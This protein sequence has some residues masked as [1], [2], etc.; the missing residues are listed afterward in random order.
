MLGVRRAIHIL[1]A[2]TVFVAGHAAAQNVRVPT[3]YDARNQLIG[4][5][6]PGNLVVVTVNKK[7]YTVSFNKNGF[8]P[9]GTPQTL[10]LQSDCT[11]TKYTDAVQLGAAWE[12]DPTEFLLN[13][14]AFINGRFFTS[15]PPYTKVS[16]AY[17]ILPERE[18]ACVV[19]GGLGQTYW[20]VPQS[21]IQSYPSA[22]IPPFS[23]R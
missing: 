15:T 18:N 5:V 7:Q 21:Q 19:W 23:L 20:L 6:Y 10:Y 8:I 4:P 3:L 22:Y 13:R 2:S 14:I 17:I 11:G 16:N 9:D 1:L 12:G